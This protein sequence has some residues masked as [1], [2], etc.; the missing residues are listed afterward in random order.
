MSHHHHLAG[1]LC[2]LV[3]VLCVAFLVLI[4]RGGAK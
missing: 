2:F 4:A 1:P 3:F